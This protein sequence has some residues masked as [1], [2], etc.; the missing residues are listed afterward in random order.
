[1]NRRL[2]GF[3]EAGLL[4]APARNLRYV[5]GALMWNGVLLMAVIGV[6][7]AYGIGIKPYLSEKGCN[8][9]A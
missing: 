3:A 7:R 6:A 4:V 5:D 1:M 2:V 8:A 9:L